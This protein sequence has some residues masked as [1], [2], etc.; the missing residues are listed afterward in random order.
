MSDAFQLDSGDPPPPGLGA[1]LDHAVKDLKVIWDEWHQWL[2]H[3]VLG[4]SVVFRLGAIILAVIVILALGR[5]FGREW[6]RPA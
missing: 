4:E 3:D 5:R 1:Q 6:T 2:Q